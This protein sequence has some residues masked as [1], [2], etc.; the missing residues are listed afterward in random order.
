ML[1]TQRRAEVRM[2]GVEA[3]NSGKAERDNP[4]E[5][6]TEEHAVW[7]AG[8]ESAD[9]EVFKRKRF[10]AESSLT[11]SQRVVRDSQEWIRTGL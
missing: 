6:G 9:Y 11:P 4:H 2:E 7:L 5:V 1:T 8:W 3:F 10:N